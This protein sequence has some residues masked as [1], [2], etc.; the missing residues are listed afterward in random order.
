MVFLFCKLER[1]VVL[2]ALKSA[3]EAVLKKSANK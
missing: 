2:E 3:Y 1:A